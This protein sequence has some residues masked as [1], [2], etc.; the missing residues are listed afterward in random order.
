L[1]IKKAEYIYLGRW[2]KRYKEDLR[3]VAI[4]RAVADPFSADG[5]LMAAFRIFKRSFVEGISSC[6]SSKQDQ[7]A[8]DAIHEYLQGKEKTR[9]T[10]L[11]EAIDNAMPL[12]LNS[13]MIDEHPAIRELV[14]ASGWAG[15]EPEYVD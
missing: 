4:M 6:V 7:A 11:R 1:K 2:I 5:L 14:I 3:D 15:G 12:L 10:K 8:V 9:E 13:F